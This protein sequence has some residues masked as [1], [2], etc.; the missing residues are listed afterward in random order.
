LIGACSFVQDAADCKV[1]LVTSS[2]GD[3]A[4]T[5]AYHVTALMAASQSQ[6]TCYVRPLTN[7]FRGDVLVSLFHQGLKSP[8]STTHR[9]FSTKN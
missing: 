6:T 7:D 2:C 4:G 8:H 3:E 1:A 9:P 5:L